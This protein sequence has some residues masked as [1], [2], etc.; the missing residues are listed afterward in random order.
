M[1]FKPWSI[2]EVSQ[3][4]SRM[5][6]SMSEILKQVDEAEGKSAKVD[7]LR[8]ND[9][10]AL[11]TILTACYNPNVKWLLPEGV[12]PYTP[13][14]LTDIEGR[15][16]NEAKH[17]Y[18]F[19]EGGNPNLKQVRREQ[20]FIQMLESIDAEDAKL[21]IGVKDSKLP[22]K[23]ITKKLVQDAFPGIF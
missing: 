13:S 4:K 7:I 3:R 18:L 12:P 9:S 8:V 19:V 21:L 2:E 16:Y 23:S 22:Y 14:N 15:L 5:R 17:L 10:Q 20:L 1:N 11:R 6:L